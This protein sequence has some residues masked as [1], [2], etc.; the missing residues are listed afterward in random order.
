VFKEVTTVTLNSNIKEC[1]VTDPDSFKNKRG[2]AKWNE[3]HKNIKGKAGENPALWLINRRKVL[4]L[5]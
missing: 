1:K 2:W 3:I 4:G 5:V